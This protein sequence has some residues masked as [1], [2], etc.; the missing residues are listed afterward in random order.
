MDSWSQKPLAELIVHILQTHHVPLPGELQRLDGLLRKVVAV[1]G[2]KDPARFAELRDAF[3]ALT[4]DLLPHMQKEERVLFPWIL[5]GRQP[6][7][8]MPIRVME[9]DHA[10]VD[11]LLTTI[12]RLTWSYVAPADAC[13]TWRALWTGLAA[14]DADL[15]E[16]MRLEN[17]VLFPRAL[18]QSEVRAG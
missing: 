12:R 9:Q 3:D 10:L 14:L 16:H 1:H 2:N 8:A 6:A 4:A 5:S 18:A 7:P 15:R 17:D 11:H 13:S